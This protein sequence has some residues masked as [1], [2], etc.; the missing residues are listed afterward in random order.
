MIAYLDGVMQRQ[1]VD[2]IVIN[3]DG[4]GYKVYVP[5]RVQQGLTTEE[6]VELHIY[7]YVREDALKLYGFAD[8]ASLEVFEQMLGVSRIGPKVALGVLGTMP[9][10]EFKMA[11]MNGDV[12]QLKQVK[13]IGKKTAKRLILELQEKLELEE[14]EVSGSE[15]QVDDSKVKE[16][17]QGLVNLGYSQSQA[18]E[19]VSKVLADNQ[20]LAVEKVIRK[21]L[22][23]LNK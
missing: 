12:K 18:R 7:T 21:G 5:A 16:A 2:Y 17:V 4:V 6:E 15:Q 13:G 11:V 22:N 14:V 20:D 8:L 9:V 10:Q 1:G 3:V 23:Y 19:A